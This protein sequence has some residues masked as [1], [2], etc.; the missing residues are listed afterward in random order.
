[1]IIEYHIHCFG[2]TLYVTLPEDHKHLK[3]EILGMLDEYYDE[4]QNSDEGC[5]CEEYMMDR[6]SETY[7]AWEFWESIEWEEEYEQY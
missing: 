7:T 3:D 4:W 5:C 2:R 6:L 1:M